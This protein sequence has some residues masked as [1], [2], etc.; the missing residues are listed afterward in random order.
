[1]VKVRALPFKK[2]GTLLQHGV[3][4]GSDVARRE[5]ESSVR[6]SSEDDDEAQA[7][8]TSSSG[9]G[10]KS[11]NS[12]TG[13]EGK[14][15][16]GYAHAPHF[17]DERKP[18]WWVTLADAK[19]SRIIVQPSKCTDI[20]PDAVRTFSVQFQAPPQVGLYSFQAI[21]KSDSYLASEA[22]MSVLLKID[23][24]SKLDDDDYEDDISDPEEDTLAGQMA[25]MRGERVKPAAFLAGSDEDDESGTDDDREGSGQQS[26]S[27]SDSDWD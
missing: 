13:K 27:D 14:Q 9:K 26:R 19:Q 4:P 22:S 5:H 21:V 1:M 24:P 10:A 16:I 2:D 17:I 11:A 12:A 8:L 7:A 15:L 3:R 23:D 6:P 20:G 18:Q 25:A